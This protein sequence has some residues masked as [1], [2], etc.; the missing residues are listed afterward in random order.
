MLDQPDSSIAADAAHPRKANE[1]VHPRLKARYE[2]LRFS[3]SLGAILLGALLCF[4]MYFHLVNT[5]NIPMDRPPRRSLHDIALLVFMLLWRSTS[6]VATC[7]SLLA[8]RKASG[9]P[10][11]ASTRP[12]CQVHRGHVLSRILVRDRAVAPTSAPSLRERLRISVPPVPARRERDRGLAR[13]PRERDAGGTERGRG[14]PRARRH[15]LDQLAV[16]PGQ[17]PHRDEPGLAELE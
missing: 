5:L 10:G 2:L 12:A 15:S 4:L 13:P 17:P 3:L 16:R 6:V 8:A 1:S 11:Q 9:S 14:H 7:D